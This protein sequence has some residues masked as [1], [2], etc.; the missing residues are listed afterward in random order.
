MSSLILQSYLDE[1]ADQIREDVLCVGGLLANPQHLVVMQNAWTERLRVPDEIEFFHAAEC[2]GVRG[3]FSKLRKKY[4]SDA[5]SVADKIRADLEGILLS[6]PWIGFGIGI[7]ISDYREL[8]NTIPAVRSFYSKDPIEAAYMSTFFEA[9]RATQK[10]A[11]GYEIEFFIDDSD[12]SKT[13]TNAFEGL[14]KNHPELAATMKSV[15]P[16]NDK[17]TPALQM[18]DLA[19]SIVKG[20]FLEWLATRKPKFVPLEMPQ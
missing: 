7:V 9:V 16:A 20:V 14:K 17:L 3:A 11:P 12:Y 2:R 8:W 19:A 13:I 15:I 5:Q 1:S 6:F 10:N 4:G 18:A